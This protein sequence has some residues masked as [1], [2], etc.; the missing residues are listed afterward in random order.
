[1]HNIIINF[2]EDG[3]VMSS[4]KIASP[5]FGVQILEKEEKKKEGSGSPGP[6]KDPKQE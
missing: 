6:R 3:S 2:Q 4:R 5:I 1:M